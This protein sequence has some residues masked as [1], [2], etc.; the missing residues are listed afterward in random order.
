MKVV[1]AKDQKTILDQIAVEQL[2]GS[3]SNELQVYLREKQVKT[4]DEFGRLA[5]E[6]VQARKSPIVDG[7]YVSYQGSEVKKGRG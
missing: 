2:I 6:F 5:N 4:V 1:E 7:K 3:V